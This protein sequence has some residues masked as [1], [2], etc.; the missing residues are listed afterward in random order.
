M[1]D[2]FAKRKG[3]EKMNRA[4]LV[5][6]AAGIGSRIR[7]RNQAV[8]PVGPNGEIIMDYSIVDAME[9]GLIKS[10]L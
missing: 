10:Y 6:M 1:L 4:T 5:I 9:A 8:E 2:Y 3:E 7:W